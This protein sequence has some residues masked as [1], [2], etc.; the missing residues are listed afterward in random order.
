MERWLSRFFFHKP[1]DE[2][3]AKKVEEAEAKTGQTSELNLKQERRRRLLKKA[4]DPSLQSMA[5]DRLT[6]S[7][8]Q[9]CLYGI[10][11]ESRFISIH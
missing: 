9:G 3:S 5:E 10:L 1:S 4:K 2:G 7:R 8:R 6:S 11:P